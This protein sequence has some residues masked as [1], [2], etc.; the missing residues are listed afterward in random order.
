MVKSPLVTASVMDAPEL[1]VLE[2]QREAERHHALAVD[3][4]RDMKLLLD[5]LNPG[6]R[7]AISTDC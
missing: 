6:K 5:E 3:M 2:A 7:K 1:Q 4:I